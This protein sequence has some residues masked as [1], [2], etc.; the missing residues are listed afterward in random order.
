MKKTINKKDG[1]TLVELLICV[2]IIA[3]LLAIVLPSILNASK[4][5]KEKNQ[6]ASEKLILNAAKVY[7]SDRKA[8]LFNDTENCEIITVQNVINA[9]YFES[10]SLNGVSTTKKIKLTLKNDAVKAEYGSSCG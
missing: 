9:G 4:R 6:Q 5:I 1:F 3:L 7:G 10:E 8:K 2:A